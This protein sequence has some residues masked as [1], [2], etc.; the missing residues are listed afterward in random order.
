MIE[1]VAVMLSDTLVLGYAARPSP[2][3][4][5]ITVELRSVAGNGPTGPPNIRFSITPSPDVARQT[6]SSRTAPYSV[7]AGLTRVQGVGDHVVDRGSVPV[8]VAA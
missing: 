8:D 2:R 1:F 4:P 7:Q 3:G 5:P 6:L